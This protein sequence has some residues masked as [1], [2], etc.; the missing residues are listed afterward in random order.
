MKNKPNI[1]FLFSDQHNAR[2]MSNAGHPDVRTP[3]LDRLAAEGMRFDNAYANNP[4]C[5]PSRISYLSSLYPSTHGYYALYGPSPVKPMTSLFKHFRL[6]GYRTGAL[7]K[8]HT[9][10]YW[11]ETDC[12]FVYDEFIEFPKYLE[13]A[14]L[15]E[16]NDNRNFTGHRD[17]EMSTLP[18][19]HSCESALAKQAIRFLRNEGEPKDRGKDDAP[20]IGWISFSRPHHPF[21]PSSPFAGMYPPESLTLPP[22]SSEKNGSKAEPIEEQQLRKQLSAYLGLV[23]QVDAAIGTILDELERRGELENT[24][25]VY[26]SDHGD[27]AAEHGLVEKYGGLSHRAITRVPLIVRMPDQ[28]NAGTVVDGIVEA[29]DL[30]PTLCELADIPIPNTVQGI[31]YAGTVLRGESSLRD[32]ALTENCYRKALATK[33]WRYVANLGEQRD[34][35]Y[36]LESDPWE[37]RN[38]IDDPAHAETAHRMLRKLME[39]VVQANK[40]VNVMTGRGWYGHVYDQDGRADLEQSG[41]PN[42]YW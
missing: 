26:T 19:E 27:F 20:C 37:L 39:R 17:G 34:E 40:P 38:L 36:D 6:N 28:R 8:L 11:I 24:I 23:S 25:I 2:C 5:T 18:Y 32:S 9:P 13:G 14:G 10:R 42:G 16:L 4:I 7:G 41:Q 22:I 3:N 35:L 1:L 31:S 12:Q 33:G 15:Y 21:T 30:F 29:V